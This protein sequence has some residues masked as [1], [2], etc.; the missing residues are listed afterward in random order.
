MSLIYKKLND[1]NLDEVIDFIKNI[2]PVS[3][4]IW[5][6]EAGRFVDWR[7]GGNTLKL[8]DNPDWF[9]DNS[10]LFQQDK[11][12][13]AVIISESGEED[14]CI[15]TKD[16]DPE[17]LKEILIWLKDNWLFKR[18]KLRLEFSDT[19]EW[20]MDILKD[21]GFQ[22]ETQGGHEWE[23]DLSIVPKI[24]VLPGGYSIDS[25]SVEDEDSLKGVAEVIINAFRS[26]HSADSLV[27][28]QKTFSQNPLYNPKLNLVI[29][30][31]KG[32]IATYCRGIVNP[33]NGICGIDP[34]CCHSDFLRQGLAKAV[35]QECFKRQ[36]ELG[37]KLCYIGSAH[38]PAPSTFLYQSL[39]PISYTT[40]VNWIISRK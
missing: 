5:G 31:E 24:P 7:W 18:N 40:S 25:V 26:Q 23:Y 8:K 3:E 13:Q 15:L 29:R 14:V 16:R 4:K 27:T 33:D 32:R 30:D 20:L 2:S 21:F 28:I 19:E 22:Q 12:L 1:Q 38:I 17:N 10:A 35:V 9:K 6:W 11:R 39:K 34:V 36:F 37:G